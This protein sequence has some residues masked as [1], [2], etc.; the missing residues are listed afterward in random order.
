MLGVFA[1][2]STSVFVCGVPFAEHYREIWLPMEPVQGAYEVSLWA[3]ELYENH[4]D[5]AISVIRRVFCRK[6]SHR[7]SRSPLSTLR[8]RLSPEQKRK[9]S[10]KS[11]SEGLE[12]LRYAFGRF[13][14]EW[15]YLNLLHSR[16]NW[17]KCIRSSNRNDLNDLNDSIE[18]AHWSSSKIIENY[19][20]ACV[21]QSSKVS[22]ETFVT[23]FR[24][25]PKW[26]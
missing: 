3:F 8:I 12:F 11:S 2:G 26:K 19:S 25:E 13:L 14:L 18:M 21:I 22:R 20:N 10:A 24:S 17:I 5:W 7:A 16:S 23:N 15:I 6:Q 1:Q 9:T 4:Q